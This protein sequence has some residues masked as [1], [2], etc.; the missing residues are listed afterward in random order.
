MSLAPVTNFITC[1]RFQWLSH[2]LKREEN[3][4]LQVSV[5]W[6]PLIKRSR[7]HP[8][9]GWIGGITEI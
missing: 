8:T 3:D 6:K 4:C 1:L 5:E 7:R 9:K 2:I